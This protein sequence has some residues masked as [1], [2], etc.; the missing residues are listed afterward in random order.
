MKSKDYTLTEEGRAIFTTINGM[1]AALERH[2]GSPWRDWGTGIVIG[3]D[4]YDLLAGYLM[5][6]D[7]WK[8][9]YAS[10]H[11]ELPGDVFGIPLIIIDEP[12]IHVGVKPRLISLYGLPTL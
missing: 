12:G 3:K 11:G 9:T 1:V 2:Y 4:D 5:N 8:I 10:W 7:V 6:D